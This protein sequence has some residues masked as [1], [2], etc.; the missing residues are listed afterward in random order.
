MLLLLMVNP[1][2]AQQREDGNRDA[3]VKI[4]TVNS[5]PDYFNP[6]KMLN[7]GNISGS[8]CII[9]GKRILTNAHVVA[10]HT[11]IQVRRYGQAKRF[12]ARILSVSHEADLALLTVED[13]NFFSGVTPLKFG[14]LPETQQEVLVYG[15]PV[16][17]D[18]LSITKGI[19]SRIEHQNYVHS[20]HYFLAGQIDAAI[21]PGNS[22]GP[23]LV[24]N[25][26]VGVVMQTYSS[27]RSENI[28]YMVPSLIIKHFL[29]DI[30]D[31]KYDGFP[32]IG[33]ATQKLENP[34]MKR[35][36]GISDTMTGIVVNHVVFGSPAEG[37]IFKDDILLSID[38]HTIGDDGTL[39]FREK[40]RTHFSHYINMHQLGEELNLEVF[41]EGSVS[42]V[43]L[44]LQSTQTDIQLVSRE[45][46]DR[47]PRYFIFGGIVFSPLTK[48]LLKRWGGRWNN[49][50]PKEL[51]IELSNWPS[52][53]R[54][55]VVV[56]V[57]VLAADVNQGYH[58]ISNWIA[59]EVNGKRI[60]DFNEL[61]HIVTTSKEP[62]IVFKNDKGFRIVI[63]REKA[64][65]SRHQILKT[66]N[67]KQ[68]R[69]SDLMHL[70]QVAE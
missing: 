19:L 20:S 63:D 38:G 10:D 32:A 62:F 29:L 14:E 40:E 39:E 27:S 3:I 67:I 61:Y 48:N 16:G 18:S 59:T 35:K 49:K 15:F 56:A 60:K 12:S 22:G 25:K 30:E 43:S 51:V 37:K 55:E 4:Y 9:K 64:Q 65:K 13:E 6:W 2:S 23:V 42:H 70:D 1:V 50:A 53:E 31:G 21:N 69:S 46:Y 44:P 58:D 68:D 36:Y 41:R 26:I 47:N 11:F 54:R 24:K 52:R 8:G 34:D 33:L 66:Y 5:K 28:G 17:G 57:Q 45:Q 7:T